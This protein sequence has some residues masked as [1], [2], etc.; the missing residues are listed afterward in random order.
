M[1]TTL[2]LHD[3]LIGLHCCNGAMTRHA[4]HPLAHTAGQLA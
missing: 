4:G 2:T 3:R 1:T